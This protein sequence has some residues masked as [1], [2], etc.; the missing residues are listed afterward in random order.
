MVLALAAGASLAGSAL[1]AD[2]RGAL[3]RIE[4][5]SFS[6]SQPGFYAVVEHVARLSGTLSPGDSGA[7]PADWNALL[8]RP[9]EFRGK[10]VTVVG[11]V[12]RVSSWKLTDERFADLPTL[13]QLELSHRDQ[14]IA[15]TAILTAAAGDIP[16]G[17]TI[18][19]TGYF[20][21][22]RQYYGASGRARQSALIVGQG[23]SRVETAGRSAARD[24]APSAL[25]AVIAASAILAV[26]WF[27]LRRWVQ[28]RSPPVELR[29]A[30]PAALDLSADLARWAQQPDAASPEKSDL[31]GPDVH[32]RP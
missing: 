28:S 25:I 1:P 12:G 7:I 30:R 13:W 22:I 18:A 19:V 14:P 29:Q 27:A 20:V 23:P 15:C 26:A 6:F 5:H 4:D 32:E 16:L 21:M 8:E 9:A 3:E 2:V 31:A 17:A 24:S 10:L 11:E